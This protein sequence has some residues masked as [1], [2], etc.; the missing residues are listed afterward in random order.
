MG[1]GIRGFILR[2]DVRNKGV[3]YKVG[4]SIATAGD[5]AIEARRQ[6][7]RAQIEQLTA[8][9]TFLEKAGD[10]ARHL[11][12]PKTPLNQADMQ[13]IDDWVRGGWQIINEHLRK[14]ISQQDLDLFNDPAIPQMKN[15][16]QVGTL[17]DRVRAVTT[18]LEHL[19][20]HAGTTYRRAG[21][22]NPD[23]Y[24]T[25]IQ[26]GDYIQD[27][28]FLASSTVKG[29]E[30][31]ASGWGTKKK[32]VYFEIHGKTGKDISPYSEISGEREVLFKPGT[33][34]KV[35]AISEDDEKVFVI[36]HEVD[37]QKPAKNP[38]NGDPVP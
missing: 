25:K 14:T 26:P 19:P 5:G 12:S 1:R 38:Y 35:D 4:G 22:A 34:F 16:V 36:M 32:Q 3:R 29:G 24:R 9:S 6:E 8:P 15:G 13:A 11:L 28:G 7:I 31:A 17:D 20:D 21:Y 27:S 23:V 30:G 10:T 37:T 18:A 2:R 33:K